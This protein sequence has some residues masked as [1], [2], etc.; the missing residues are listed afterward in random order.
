MRVVEAAHLIDGEL[1]ASRRRFPVV[2][3]ALGVAFADCPDAGREELD[4]AV[5]AARR[6]LP[7][8]SALGFDARRGMLNRLAARLREQAEPLSALLTREQGKPLAAAEAEIV[9]TARQIEELAAIALETEVLREDVRE[10]IELRY[11]P[12]GVVAGIAPW[13]A[14]VALAMHK[15]AQA[16]YTGNCLV[17]KPSPCT[18]LTALAIG[19]LAVDVFPAGVLNILAGGDALGAWLTGHEGIDKISFT[20]SVATGRKVMAAAGT[21]LRRISLEL[22]G[23]DPAIVLDD[24]DLDVAARGIAASAYANCGQICMAVKRVYTHEA[25]HDDLVERL[26]ALVRAIRVGPGSEAGVTMGPIQNHMQYERVLGLIA[27]TRAVPGARFVTGGEVLPGGGYFVT[28]ALVTGLPD[29][30]RLVAEEQFGPVLPVLRFSTTTDAVHRANATRYGLGASIWSR[31]LARASRLAGQ[32]EAG[33]VWINR[34]GGNEAGLPFG[35]VKDW[36]IGREQG[37]LGLR[38]YMEA[39]TVAIPIQSN[40]RSVHG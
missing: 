8:W 17:L 20:G 27:A 28:P 31:D 26:T 35:G 1:V 14:P 19:A 3:P 37:L 32:I 11:R 16:L 5:T 7:E 34:H 12:I 18:P 13:N 6:A 23:N 40:Q 25:I 30:A 24:A 15:V 39:Q 21:G 36:G 38:S 10:R 2:D 33:M 9:R 22:G 4:R 29:D